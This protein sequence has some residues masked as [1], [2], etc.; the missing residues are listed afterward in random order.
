[1]FKLIDKKIREAFS[2]AA[3]QYDVLASL[4]REI[5]RELVKKIMT[6]EHCHEA[7][8]VG[9][10]TGWLANRLTHVFPDA[11]VVGVDFA[12][13]MIEAA[14]KREGTFEI[15][16]ADARCLPFE[17]NTFDIVA[18]NLAYQW[19]SD[20][21]KSFNECYRVLKDKGYLYFTLFGANTFNELFDSLEF[22]FDGD[23]LP[24][25]RL[26]DKEQVLIALESSGFKNIQINVERINT[27][28]P[29][30][31][32]LIK[33]VKDIGANALAKD[34]FVG[35]DL[36][37]RADH[38]YEKNFREHLGILATLEVIWVEGSKGV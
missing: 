7:L 37:Q 4:H 10:G 29:N 24:I 28:F 32:V 38:Y 18:S 21:E 30:M 35:K 34:F 31:M 13:G 15:V 11:K 3:M 14:K 23:T 25:K 17:E 33:W 27:H 1:M 36:L 19:M 20:L 6:V 26:A 12:Q 9:M 5:G 22:A 16:Q 2:D 8:D